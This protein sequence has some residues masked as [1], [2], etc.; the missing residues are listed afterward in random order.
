[1]ALEGD[2]F[3]DDHFKMRILN[4]STNLF[5]YRW[6]MLEKT[7]MVANSLLQLQKLV[8]LMEGMLFLAKS[9]KENKLLKQ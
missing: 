1:M 8:G 5:V 3:G 9:L 7:Q 2:L 4:Y 6:L